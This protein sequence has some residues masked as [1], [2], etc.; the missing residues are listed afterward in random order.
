M[1]PL[2]H[3]I[4]PTPARSHLNPEFLKFVVALQVPL[5]ICLALA[6]ADSMTAPKDKAMVRLAMDVILG[7]MS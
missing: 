6:G 4:K 3:T 7:E 2:V 1:F 5:D